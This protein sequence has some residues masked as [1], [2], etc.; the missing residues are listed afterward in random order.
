MA[1]PAGSFGETS[2]TVQVC[3]LPEHAQPVVRTVQV[4]RGA[5]LAD[6]VT[7]SGL[8]N[9]LPDASWR[10][11]GGHLRLAVHGV[12]KPA[13][14]VVEAGERIDITRPL[15]IDPKEARRQRARKAARTHRATGG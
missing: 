12:L 13:T 1:E 11:A 7:A 2:I 3:W 14:A 6:A 5:S 8:A 9:T 15:T 10:E 4:P